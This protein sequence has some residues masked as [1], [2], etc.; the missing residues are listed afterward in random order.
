M[1]TYILLLLIVNRLLIELLLFVERVEVGD[2]KLHELEQ[3]VLDAFFALEVV[4]NLSPV[5][6]IAIAHELQQLDVV[7]KAPV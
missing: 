7:V 4:L 2:G 1:H 3:N 5:S 6:S